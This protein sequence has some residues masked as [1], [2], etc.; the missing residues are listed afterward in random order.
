SQRREIVFHGPSFAPLDKRTDRSRSSVEHIHAMALDHAPET[1][2][3]GPVWRAFVH[4]NRSAVR[5]WTIN[6]VAVARH[7]ADVGGAPVKILVF[8][9]ED[10]LRCEMRLQ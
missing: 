10:P 3:L 2:W 1:I 8:E 6:D 5:E 4:Q 7:P 9:I